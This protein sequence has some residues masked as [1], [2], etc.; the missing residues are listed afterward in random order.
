MALSRREFL[1]SGVT[2]VGTGVLM[3]LV[4]RKAL[5]S[6]GQHP[7]RGGLLD[8]GRVLVVVQMAGGNDGLNTVIPVTDGRYHD[9]RPDI[10]VAQSDALE[11]DKAT[12]LH[13][14]MSKVKE[15]WDR[16]VVAIVQGVGYPQP[17][18]SHFVA[19]DIWQKA[20]PA[21]K[22]RDGWLGRYF[23]RE[24]LRQQAPFLGLAIGNSTPTSFE[25]TTVAEPSLES[26]NSYQ[27]LGDPQAPTLTQGRLQTLVSMYERG[28]NASTYGP[29][30]T[31]TIQTAKNSI[32]A[33]QNA[34]QSYKP[35]VQYPKDSLSSALQLV[36]EA[37]SANVGVKIC[38]VAIGGFDTHA[39]QAVDQP[40]QLGT[41]SNAL[42]AFYADLKARKLDS[43]VVIM[44]WSEFGRRVKSN[45]SDGT[46][47]GSAGPMFLLGTPVNGGLY[48]QQ[49]D[50]GNLDNGN[51]RYTVDFRSVYTTVLERWLSVP[52]RDIL[53]GVYQPIMALR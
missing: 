41:L 1:K 15:L 11:L 18:F 23:E 28:R 20:D 5:V 8:D 10:A 52:A 6:L 48:G 3:P 45:A 25:A 9:A 44:T 35:S 21:D 39:F 4:F 33:L 27:F 40:R 22:L 43:K 30:L 51:L 47:H 49:P 38:H 32:E 7:W 46:D 13:P 36:A 31:E 37:I 24:H 16:G 29:L 50:L 17:N 14:S 26:I 34:N 2:V 53:D 19:M 42:G 12:G